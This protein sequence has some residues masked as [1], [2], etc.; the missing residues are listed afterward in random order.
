MKTHYSKVLLAIACLLAS[1]M[2]CAN[3]PTDSV[4]DS[5]E[6]IFSAGKMQ[7]IN[8]A[9]NPFVYKT[10]EKARPVEPGSMPVPKFTIKT[11]NNQFMLTIG[12]S[13]NPYLSY[14]IGNDLYDTDAGSSFITGDIPVPAM[15]GHK[16]DFFINALHGNLD[17]TMVAF[18]DS[19][20][21]VTGY[22]KI[23]ANGNDKG[24]KLKRAYLTWRNISA[25]LKN[26]VAMDEYAAQPSTIDPQGPGGEVNTASYQISYRSPH[27]NGF[28]F[29]GSIEMP[30]YNNSEGIYRGHDFQSWYGHQVNAEVSQLIPDIPLYVE[31]AP[32]TRNR[33]R[34]TAILRNFGYQNMLK[35]QRENVFA[36]GTMLSGN[37]AIGK[38]V[39]L[40]LQ[41]VYGRGI[42]HYIQ[43]L[44][45]RPLSFT[46]KDDDPGKM[47][48]NPMMGLVF[49]AQYNATSRLQFNAVGSYSR[50][51]NVGNYATV[52]DQ[53]QADANGDM[54]MTAG[55][56]NY[57][58]GI[59]VA[60]NCFYRFTS[61][62]KVGVE[63]IW[64]RHVTYGLGGANDSRISTQIAINF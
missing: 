34:F 1:G 11:D 27:Y 22:I 43:D 40:Y 47:V 35:K 15:T 33:V 3:A 64:G 42:G 46:P 50:V 17:F 16:G 32:S 60:A 48:A 7:L 44:Q 56:T 53:S 10:I 63:Y 23:G 39:T 57:R 5:G 25:G 52:D 8:T 26:T 62:L 14:D 45:G 6:I 38:P 51:W 37:I 24:L 49:G 20:N 55:N 54:V 31:Y 59:Y 21:Q 2:A 28:G 12:G 29:A 58:Y 4:T 41:A 19:H 18:P 36:W 13:I 9:S 30:T 61:F